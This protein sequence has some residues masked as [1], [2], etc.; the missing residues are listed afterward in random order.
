MQ[1]TFPAPYAQ[2]VYVEIGSGDVQVVATDTDQAVVTVE[3]R[4]AD[5]VQVEQDGARIRVVSRMRTGFLSGFQGLRIHLTIPRDSTLSTRL[6]SAGVSVE[7]VLEGVQVQTGSGEVTLDE[8]TD[9]A[10]IKTGS[11]AVAVRRIGAQAEVKTGSGDI[12][13]GHLGGPSRLTT[14]SG[15]IEVGRAD[16]PISFKTGSGDIVVRDAQGRQAQL[17]AGSGQLEVGR[18][19]GGVAQ[20]KNA[21][22]DIRFGVPAG[23]PVWTDV[24]SVSGHVRSSLTPTGAPQEGQDHV[25]VTARTVSGDVYLESI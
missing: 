3:G 11:G 12:G 5:E 18:M 17:S 8:V 20:L 1:H 7:G 2:D 4:D 23:T 13:I 19:A 24:S 14:G 22:G 10:V 16:G 25:E 6:G 9:D 21:S 15:D